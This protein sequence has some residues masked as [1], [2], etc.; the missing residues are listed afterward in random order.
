MTASA[1]HLALTRRRRLELQQ[2]AQSV[3]SGLMYSSPQSAFGGFQIAA[4]AVSSLR[5]D[6]AQQLIYFA[7]HLLMDCN[8]RFFS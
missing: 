8:S 2:L 1:G 5:E 7:R 4:R 3:G 6:A